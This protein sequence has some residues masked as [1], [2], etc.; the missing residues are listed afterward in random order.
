MRKEVIV[1]ILLGFAIGL[2]V[3][4]G[5]ITAQTAMKQ[6]QAGSTQPTNL[7][8]TPAATGE[9]NESSLPVKHAVSVTDPGDG[10][11]VSADQIVVSGKTTP[12]SKVVVSGEVD[13]VIVESDDAGLFSEKLGLVSGENEIAVVSFAPSLERAEASLTI[14]YTT[15]EF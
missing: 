9:K 1:A 14:V 4:F 6:Y 2:L 3:I 12:K 5:I 7:T 8:T 13:D 11:V 15:A 10:H